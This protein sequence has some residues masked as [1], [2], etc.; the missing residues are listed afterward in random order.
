MA[1]HLSLPKTVDGERGQF[2]LTSE[3]VADWL[4]DLTDDD[5]VERGRRILSRLAEMNRSR[6]RVTLRQDV[7]EQIR[8]QVLALL[9]ELDSSL[10]SHRGAS[11]VVRVYGLS[12]QGPGGNGLR[13]I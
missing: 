13:L 4:R 10:A 3:Q 1:L 11:K 5:P 8:A 7:T 2:T 12:L 6:V 9:P